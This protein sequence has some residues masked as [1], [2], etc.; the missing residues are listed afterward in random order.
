MRLNL[1]TDFRFKQFSLSHDKSAFKIGTDSILLGSWVSGDFRSIVDLGCGCGV[2]A[3]MC[4]QRFEQARVLGVE[5]DEPSFAQAN[6]NAQNS[7]WSDRVDVSQS[8]VR[9][10]AGASFDL[11]ISNP[12]YFEQ[13]VESPNDRKNKA[14]Q[15]THLT[16][17]EL[18][19]TANRIGHSKSIVAVVFPY[20]RRQVLLEA[21]KRWGWYLQKEL[22][23][24]SQQGKQAKLVLAQFSRVNS[25]PDVEYLCI[26]NSSGEYSPEFKALTGNFYLD[27]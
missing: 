18:F 9:K 15:E 16:I 26:A 8:D 3:L 14:R 25:E 11:I 12:P 4:A 24:E 22:R 5:L 17:S 23:V 7:P 21:A 27:F 10:L 6:S 2:L 1:V 19:E 13:H 20:D